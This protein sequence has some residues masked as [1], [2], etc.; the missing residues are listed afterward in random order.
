V[1]SAKLKQRF[2]KNPTEFILDV[3]R[4]AD[5][6]MTAT[7]IMGNLVE[8]GLPEELVKK[9][10]T[11][12]QRDTVKYHPYIVRPTS[13]SY[14]WQKEPIGPGEA[15]TRMLDLLKITS[16]TKL[17]VRDDLADLV[18]SGLKAASDS[19]P[20]GDEA[21]FRATQ[22]RQTRVDGLRAVAELAGEIEELAY[23]SGDPDVIVERV[24]TRVEAQSIEQIGRS[25][26]QTRFDS[27]RHEAI[28][29]P[30]VVGSAVT[31]VRPGYTWRT[32][33]EDV[34]LQRALVAAE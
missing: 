30:P 17:K 26:E 4:D 8:R 14:A 1:D 3:L 18:R 29:R 20:A 15:L 31:V 22:E 10:W 16:S 6:P 32:D 24:Q 21:R 25:G 11:A 27:S 13:R 34:L 23:N 9:H 12:V 2:D 5:R 28:G 19:M 7:K 33:Q